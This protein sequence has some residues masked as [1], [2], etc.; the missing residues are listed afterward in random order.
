MALLP[1]ISVSLTNSGTQ[2]MFTDDT[3]VYNAISNI[4]GYGDINA[5][6]SDVVSAIIRITDPSGEIYDYD[7][8]SQIPD[9]VTGE[10]PF[11]PFVGDWQDGIYQIEYIVNA[12]QIT[13]T[14]K[15]LVFTPKVDCCIDAKLAS[16]VDEF[17]CD[18]C[19]DNYDEMIALMYLRDALH[20]SGLMKNEKQITNTLCMLQ[21][22]CEIC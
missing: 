16:F 21:S 20:V 5:S 11:S 13:N 17:V 10:V 12:L 3:G 14:L 8:T 18:D 15:R 22:L 9:N 2:F 1:T 7:V 6:G 19:Y 4:G